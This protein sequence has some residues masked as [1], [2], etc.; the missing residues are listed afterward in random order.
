MT[1][2]FV[3]KNLLFVK[4]WSSALISKDC[5]DFHFAYLQKLFIRKNNFLTFPACF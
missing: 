3:K 1:T 5:S 4:Y 2:P